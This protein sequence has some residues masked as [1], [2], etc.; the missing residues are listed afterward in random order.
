MTHVLNVHVYQ[1][2]VTDT[3]EKV[4]IYC[5]LCS[6]HLLYIQINWLSSVPV[7]IKFNSTCIIFE[8]DRNHAEKMV[9]LFL[10]VCSP[11]RLKSAKILKLFF[12]RKWLQIT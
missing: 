11:L 4:S 6:S 1:R 12:S 3:P 2:V 8:D 5:L 7:T 10:Q 9:N